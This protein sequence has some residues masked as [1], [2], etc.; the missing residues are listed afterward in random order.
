MTK[1]QIFIVFFYC[2]LWILLFFI[3]W[4]ISLLSAFVS[5]SMYSIIFFG[6][7][8]YWK[9]SIKKT[10]LF[11]IDFLWIFLYKIS[12]F[13]IFCFWIIGSFSYYQNE[14]SPA[15]M[16]FYTI[17]NWKKIIKFQTM[18]HIGTPHFYEKVRKNIKIAKDEGYVLFFEWVRP[19]KEENMKKFDE[20]LGIN[21][22]PTLYENFSRLYGLTFQENTYFLELVNNYD[23]N[24]DL[25]IDEIIKLYEKIWENKKNNTFPKEIQD[26]DSIVIEELSKLNDKEL[27]ILIYINQAIMNFIIKNDSLQKSF[28]KEFWNE[29]LFE[30]I[31]NKRNELLV[32]NIEKSKYDK[33]F[34]TYGLLHFEWVLEKLKKIDKNR[35]IIKKE[36]LYPIH[37]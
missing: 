32:E 18:I 28:L 9:K 8:F 24:I 30:V 35:K 7:Y 33:I 1:K 22:T 16:P 17:S 26:V 15:Y 21:F 12:F 3:G 13:L 29:A 34:I 5:I 31:L 14:I 2:I 10:P 37:N 23:F 25:S 27:Q 4:I 36:Y 19:W 20:A 11:F 6:I